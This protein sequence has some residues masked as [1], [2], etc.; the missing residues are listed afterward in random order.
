[1]SE[2]PA[3]AHGYIDVVFSDR[4]QQVVS[5]N[6]LP[7]FIGR[8][9]ESGNHLV[10]DDLRISRKCAAISAGPTGICIEDR[11]QLNGIFVNGKPTGA[12]TLTDGDRI[13]LGIDD[14]CQLVFRM[15]SEAHSQ[16]EAVTKLRSLLGSLSGNSAD[17]LKA[18]RLLLEA[19]SLL[20]SELPLESVLA[21]MLDH[22]IVITHADRGMLLEPDAS[23]VLQVRVARGR[24]GESLTAETMNPSRSVL[25][26][27]MELE[28]AVINED[29][30]LADRNLQSAYSVVV[31]LLRSAAVIP[32][33]GA[34]RGQASSSTEVARHQLLGALYLDSRRTATFSAMDRQ[35]LDALGAQAASIL[36][37][38]RLL[39]RERE[40][41]RL[42][43]ELSIARQIQQA[44]VPQGLQDY[45]HLAVTGI[46]RPCHEVG[47]DYFDVFTLPDG[48][49]AIMISDV[50]GKGLGAALLTTMLQG[51]LSG[52]T[53][54]VEPVKVFNHLNSFLCDRAAVGRY[55]TMF[56]GLLDQDGGLEFVRASHPSP[57][58][59]RRGE[60]SELYSGGSFPIGLVEQASFNAARIQLEPGD[61]L[62]LYTDGVT[63]A[64]D[65][66]RNQ[67][68]VGRLKEALGRHQDGSLAELQAGILSA[69]ERFAEGASQSDDITLLVVRYQRAEDGVARAV[70][71]N[72]GGTQLPV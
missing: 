59:L 21:A 1:M 15:Q 47:G 60:V 27:A 49:I 40:R 30:R 11:G 69:V 39:E 23:G 31:Q 28:S 4:P 37:N 65:R 14:G 33:Y 12:G 45:P 63:E 66:D 56:F 61:T 25:G 36:D 20:H 13:R 51:A 53:L 29:L 44:L 52:M 9:K 7:F 70:N 6:E 71:G 10:I 46:H 17:D 42:E 50:A 18:L 68:G 58:L 26:Q 64:E 24:D 5:I 57:L 72:R 3:P 55:A 16:E 8:G 35:I 2:S 67:F 34:P 48:R 19:T 38:A 22:A 43:Q 32:L 41:Q 62:V 54:G